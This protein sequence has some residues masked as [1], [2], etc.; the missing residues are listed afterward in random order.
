MAL[1]LYIIYI[2]VYPYLLKI[3]TEILKRC[4]HIIWEGGLDGGKDETDSHEWVTVEAGYW[5]HHNSLHSSI[6]V[7]FKFPINNNN[8]KNN[9][10]V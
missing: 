10:S 2:S 3:H 8:K 7:R 5:I 9:K 4:H 1:C 6:F